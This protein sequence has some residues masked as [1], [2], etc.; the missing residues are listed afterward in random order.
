[1][2]D[3]ND[4]DDFTERMLRDQL[5]RTEKDRD[6]A[7]TGCVVAEQVALALRTDLAI[8]ASALECEC[9]TKA[10]L[11]RIEKLRQDEIVELTYYAPQY[12]YTYN[13][14]VEVRSGYPWFAAREETQKFIDDQQANG[15]GSDY[16]GVGEGK[17]P[18]RRG[19]IRPSTVWATYDDYQR[20]QITK[21]LTPYQKKLLGLPCE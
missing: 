7:R 19:D 10:V 16:V 8:I 6:V 21:M 1:M 15:N 17:R 18:M 12:Q 9:S 13:G 2:T 20:D 11:E 4:D 5:A 3:R 14:E